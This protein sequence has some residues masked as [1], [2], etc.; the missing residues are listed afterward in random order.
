MAEHSEGRPDGGGSTASPVF[1]DSS[2]GRRR[3]WRRLGW[4]LGAAGGGY[5]L[6][7]AVSMIGGNSDA[8]WGVLI[9]G[10]GDGSGAARVVPE[11]A[12]DD[13]KSTPGAATGRSSGEPAPGV[14]APAA[15]TRFVDEARVPRKS[16]QPAPGARASAGSDPERT[17]ARGNE[18]GTTTGGTGGATPTPGNP[19]AEPTG[20]VATGSTGAPTEPGTEPTS[21]P[22][23]SS[24]PSPQGGLLDRI[25]DQLAGPATAGRE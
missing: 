12:G 8:P 7:L 20:G 19:P 1:V 3:R 16:P 17:P 10:S 2:G 18:G 4:A 14:S 25:V 13:G 6:V 9:P 21:E 15:V 22:T 11:P 24:G 23:A 5:A